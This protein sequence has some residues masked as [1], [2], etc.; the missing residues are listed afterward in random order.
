LIAQQNNQCTE[1]ENPAKMSRFSSA[2]PSAIRLAVLVDRAGRELP[3]QADYV[4]LTFADVPTGHRVNVR[5]MEIDGKDEI[6][7]EPKPA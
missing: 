4:G 3:I 1:D 7:V 5:L 2:H 6:L